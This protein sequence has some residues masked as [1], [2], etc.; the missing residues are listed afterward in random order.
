MPENQAHGKSWEKEIALNV[1][2]VS[3]EDNNLNTHTARHDIPGKHNRL[4]EG[5]NVSIKTTGGDTVCMSD[6]RRVFENVGNVERLHMVVIMYNQNHSKS[7]KKINRIVEIDL[8]NSRKLLFGTA[9]IDVINELVE[10]VKSVPNDMT[11]QHK[12]TYKRMAKDIRTK[13]GG[14]ISYAP[15]VDSK[16]QRRIQCCIPKFSNFVKENPHLVI[17]ESQ[18]GEFRGGSITEEIVSPPRKRNK[19]T[20]V[21]VENVSTPSESDL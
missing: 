14:Y 16:G 2:G 20:I 13:Y 4:D 12:A 21:S 11:A 18:T 6:V 1:F 15:K 7:T 10:Y 5:V 8:T 3:E 9:T 17:A 19:K